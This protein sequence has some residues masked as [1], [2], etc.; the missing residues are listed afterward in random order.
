[1]IRKFDAEDHE[2]MVEKEIYTSEPFENKD[3]DA[4]ENSFISG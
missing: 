4:N 1:M 2:N 3:N